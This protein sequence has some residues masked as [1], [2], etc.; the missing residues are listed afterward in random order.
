MRR[1]LRPLLVPDE[2]LPPPQL[3]TW[4]FNPVNPP[5]LLPMNRFLGTLIMDSENSYESST[6]SSPIN[7]VASEDGEV[8][9]FLKFAL[10]N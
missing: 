5:T 9:E 2:N 4:Y 1:E 8:V 3:L 7:D 10:K 6:C